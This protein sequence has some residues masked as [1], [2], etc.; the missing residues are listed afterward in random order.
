MNLIICIV[1]QILADIEIKDFILV[2]RN[3]KEV[4]NLINTL[5]ERIIYIWLNGIWKER[6]II[7]MMNLERIFLSSE[8]G[9]NVRCT[10][11]N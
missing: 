4:R 11:I 7:D 5:K 3:I 10:D 8:I 6:R 9:G 2:D 1:D